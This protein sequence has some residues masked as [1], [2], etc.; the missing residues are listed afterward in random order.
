[1][2]MQEEGWPLGLLNG[3]IGL[4]ETGSDFSGSILTA[5]STTSFTLSSPDHESQVCIII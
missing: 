3:R 2:L 4:V 5:S 1:M